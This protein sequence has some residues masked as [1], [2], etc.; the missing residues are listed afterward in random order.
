MLL[1]LLLPLLPHS[2]DYN[3]KMRWKETIYIRIWIMKYKAKQ[4]TEKK[5]KKSDTTLGSRLF[6]FSG[7]VCVRRR[8]LQRAIQ[9]VCV[10][11]DKW[12]SSSIHCHRQHIHQ[13]VYL[14]KCSGLKWIF[15]VRVF[16]TSKIRRRQIE[17]ETIYA[18]IYN[19]FAYRE[20]INSIRQKTSFTA[21]QIK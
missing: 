15:V 13:W 7:V 9:Y 21:T 4:K 3:R 10:I 5:N 16:G 18:W 8:P 2:N 19:D 14:H 20:W 1:L 6:W 17:L 12:T 11:L